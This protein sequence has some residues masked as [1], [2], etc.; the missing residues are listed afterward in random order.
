MGSGILHGLAPRL[1][2]VSGLPCVCFRHFHMTR[3][4]LRFNFIAQAVAGT[5][6]AF[7]FRPVS[8]TAVGGQSARN[9]GRVPRDQRSV[10][11]RNRNCDRLNGN[12]LVTDHNYYFGPI[13]RR[14]WVVTV[15]RIPV[16][17]GS[18]IVTLAPS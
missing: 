5:G 7:V 15:G 1:P 13:L 14:G 11:S 4:D 18:N 2:A 12:L 3:Q 6:R 16:T 10:F 8:S 17:I 9:G